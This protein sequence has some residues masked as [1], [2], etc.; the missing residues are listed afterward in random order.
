[1]IT[2]IG[3]NGFGRIGRQVFKAIRERY[4]DQIDV[5]V[6]IYPADCDSPGLISLAVTGGAG[7]YTYTWDPPISAGLLKHLVEIPMASR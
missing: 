5:D 4:P 3:I 6:S 7:G 1:M 2:K